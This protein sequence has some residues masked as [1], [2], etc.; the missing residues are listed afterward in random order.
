MPVPATTKEW[1]TLALDDPLFAVAAWPGHEH[2][3]DLDAFYALGEK[4]WITFRHQWRQYGAL[5]SECIEIG[6]GAGRITKQ[7]ISDFNTVYGVDVSEAMLDLAHNAAP[8][9]TLILTEGNRLPLPDG[10]A[11][12]AFSCHVLQHLED[13]GAV[14]E[15]LL[16]LHRCLRP[17][18]TCMLHFLIREGSPGRLKRLRAEA[19]LRWTR[20][21]DANRGGYSRVRRYYPSEIRSMLETTGFGDVELREF[22]AG[23]NDAPHAFW[24]ARRSR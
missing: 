3:W 10:C 1:R 19:K 4:D 13:C 6:C 20:Y 24:L 16:E 18:A 21:R 2:S 22:A 17:G 8:T 5:G 7:L 9:A 12:A 14:T 15:A 23:S 11:D